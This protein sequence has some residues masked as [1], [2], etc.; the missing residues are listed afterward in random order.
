MNLVKPSNG[1]DDNKL[2]YSPIS[3]PLRV[4]SFSELYN[5][6]TDE[7]GL[8]A[9]AY[10][11]YVYFNDDYDDSIRYNG[12]DPEKLA[13]ALETPNSKSG[14]AVASFSGLTGG[15]EVENAPP[16][17]IYK[18][19]YVQMTTRYQNDGETIVNRNITAWTYTIALVENHLPLKKW[20]V[21]EVI[22]RA[23]DLLVPLRYG[24]KPQFRLSGVIYN[25]RTGRADGYETG[26]LAEKLDKILSPE[27]AFTKM[28]AREML[29]QV[30]GF[31]H[32]EPRILSVNYDDG[33]RWYEVGFDFYGGNEISNI[34]NIPY[35]TA[36]FGTDINDYC[37]SLDSSADNLINQLD[38]AQGVIF[39]PFYDGGKTL[40]TELTTARM[41]EDNTTFIPTTFPI[42]RVYK[43]Y[44]IA[45]LN[46]DEY[47]DQEILKLDITPYLFESADYNNLS[48]F[49]GTYPFCKAYALCYEQGQKNIRGLFF[50]NPDA[51]D[52]VFEDYAIINILKAVATSNFPVPEKNDY[53]S[54]MG[55]ICF[56]VEYIPFYSARVRTNKQI[57]IGGIPRTIAYNQT[58]NQIE[59]RYYGENLKGVIARMGNVQKT[60]TYNLAFMWEVPKVGT[61][62]DDNYYISTVSTEI[63][64]DHIQCTIGLSKD[65]NR[66]S[67]YVGVNSTKRMWEVSEKQSFE[68]ETSLT[69]YVLITT[70]ETLGSSGRP[71]ICRSNSNMAEML[72][73]KTDSN[74]EIPQVNQLISAVTVE[75]YSKKVF[76]EQGNGRPLSPEEITLPVIS[77]SF[78]NA[79]AFTFGF[80][81]NYSAGQ[82]T[83]WV[84]EANKVSGRWANYVPYGDYYGR[85]YYLILSLL[86][87]KMTNATRGDNLTQFQ[88]NYN[89]LAQKL[90]QG[91]PVRSSVGSSS[92]LI[93]YRKDSREVPQITV[94]LQAVT[95]S[96]DIIIGSAMMRNCSLVNIS[97]KSMSLVYLSK[98]LN[99]LSSRID[100]STIS[101][102]N[103][104]PISE[105]VISGKKL[106][107][108]S[109]NG[110]H[111]AWALITTPTETKIKVENDDGEEEEQTIFEGGELV[112][113]QNQK[114]QGQTLYFDYR[115]NIYN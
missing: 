39:E 64:P 12:S 13:E 48:S 50:E 74:G 80:E 93:V 79:M 71:F 2:Y 28:N 59:A 33:K 11:I 90:P 35:I 82:K 51:I 27:Y 95:D 36:K 113:G 9:Y 61:K 52:Q 40:R 76:D 42:E 8:V 86:S 30:G 102:D 105:V 70:K 45:K 23:H 88:N 78:G 94:E 103:I 53:D 18:I 81:D 97:P 17:N 114:A 108:P 100:T 87:G 68:R 21:T 6:K 67:Q 38:W 63:L 34:S 104:R 66:L 26:S 44:V 14:N 22:N 25:D 56:Q 96:E 16:N 84:A 41:R 37:T 65:F 20:T 107:V 55:G 106:T 72:L 99:T 5:G 4:Y 111:V 85:V 1:I 31:I 19:E 49:E 112:L 109:F 47:P 101:S 83:V 77:S 46:K 89:E 62:F 54:F 32:A 73:N 29:K 7:S 57:A 10:R 98:K 91:A 60:Y 92:G 110:E 24:E 15:G 43:L 115:E 58:A 3:P 69:D 75:R